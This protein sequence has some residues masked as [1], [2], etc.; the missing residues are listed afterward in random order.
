MTAHSINLDVHVHFQ[1]SLYILLH[2]CHDAG[3]PKG[4]LELINGF[5]DPYAGVQKTP[6]PLD[7]TLDPVCLAGA[8]PP[9]M[10]FAMRTYASVSL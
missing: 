6:A 3:H 7:L 8:L 1:L 10:Q 2:T 9:E 5:G 4:T